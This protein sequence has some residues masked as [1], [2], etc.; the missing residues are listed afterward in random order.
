LEGID[1]PFIPSIRVLCTVGYAPGAFVSFKAA[2]AAAEFAMHAKAHSEGVISPGKQLGLA[3]A[4]PTD[5]E[6]VPVN[7]KRAKSVPCFSP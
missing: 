4:E 5:K 1:I 7:T 6:N 2:P 3:L